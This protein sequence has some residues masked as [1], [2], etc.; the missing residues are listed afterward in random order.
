MPK[1]LRTF[2]E[3]MRRVYPNEVVSIGKPVNPLTYDVTAIIKQL[4]ALKN[5]QF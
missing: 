1:N 5:F 3:D 4:G 2:L